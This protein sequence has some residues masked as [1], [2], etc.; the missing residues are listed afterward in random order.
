V[1][2]GTPICNLHFYKLQI[3]KF[4]SDLHAPKEII[5]DNSGAT[6][7]DLATGKSKLIED[8]KIKANNILEEIYTKLPKHYSG[9]EIAQKSYQATENYKKEPHPF[10]GLHIEKFREIHNLKKELQSVIKDYYFLKENHELSYEKRVL[11]KLGFKPCKMCCLNNN[12]N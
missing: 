11:E 8:L 2:T 10:V 4:G 6:S 3:K 5:R 9:K 1:V 7:F 12:T